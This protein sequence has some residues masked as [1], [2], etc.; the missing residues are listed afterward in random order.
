MGYTYTKHR[1]LA[2]EK[3][4]RAVQE[5]AKKDIRGGKGSQKTRPKISDEFIT[6]ELMSWR[7]TGRDNF[8]CH[9]HV[10]TEVIN[11]E[12]VI[13]KRIGKHSHPPKSTSAAIREVMCFLKIV[14]GYIS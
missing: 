4:N 12:T 10:H 5:K 6:S 3:R 9:V 14:I 8:K 13:I 1:N 11:G 7:C 2:D